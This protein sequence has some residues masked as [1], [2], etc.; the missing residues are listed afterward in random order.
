MLISYILLFTLWGLYKIII[1]LH[2]IYSNCISL[3]RLDL[4]FDR[5]S[6]GWNMFL[7]VQFNW[8]KHWFRKLY[9]NIQ[10]TGHYLKQ[11]WSKPMI[12]YTGKCRYN[13][14][15][16]TTGR[17]LAQFDLILNWTTWEL[18]WATK[19][20]NEIHKHPILWATWSWPTVSCTDNV[21]NL[22]WYYIQHCD[23]SGRKWIRF[24]NHNRHP[25]PW[26][27][28]QA[29]GCLLWGFWRKLTML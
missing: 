21:V 14:V 20:Y 23:N 24:L 4:N 16:E 18:L 29:M 7:N 10:V 26:P 2:I 8:C 28:G 13:A 11:Y 25:K 6:T 19:I 15:H 9:G 3:E 5:N 12:P 17:P 22:S 27:H 1:I